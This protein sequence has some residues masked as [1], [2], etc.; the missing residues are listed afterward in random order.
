MAFFDLDSIPPDEMHDE[1]NKALSSLDTMTEACLEVL[2]FLEKY[3]DRQYHE[4]AEKATV[5]SIGGISYTIEWMKE[6]LEELVEN[7]KSKQED[8][9]CAIRSIWS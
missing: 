7:E 4:S 1:I 5:S 3:A 6:T 8:P 2:Q 9:E